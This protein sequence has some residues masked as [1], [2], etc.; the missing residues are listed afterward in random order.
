MFFYSVV[1][2]LSSNLFYLSNCLLNMFKFYTK[3]SYYFTKRHI[4]ILIIILSV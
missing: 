1:V 4:F 3:I 2:K